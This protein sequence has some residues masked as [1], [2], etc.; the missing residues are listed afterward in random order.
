MDDDVLH[1][2]SFPWP[3]NAPWQG[4][5]HASIRRGWTVYKEVCAACHSL[6]FVAYRNLVGTVLTEDEAKAEAA[7]QDVQDGP[8]K[9]GEMFYRTGKLA[10]KLAQPYA[11][12]EVARS[13][14][15]NALPPDLTVMVKVNASWLLRI[16]FLIL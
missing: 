10:D 6:E 7:D 3:S 16:N 14:N 15:N 2:P 12:D 9:N 11:N 4:F 1:P 5:D 8:D 13:S